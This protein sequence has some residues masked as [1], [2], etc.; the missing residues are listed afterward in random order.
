MNSYD[1]DNENSGNCSNKKTTKTYNNNKNNNQHESN[2]SNSNYRQQQ[3]SVGDKVLTERQLNVHCNEIF[4][5][6]EE[7]S[8]AREYNKHII[9]KKHGGIKET[10]AASC[11]ECDKR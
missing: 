7:A 8:D 10:L 9:K 11:V 2:S 6:S 1:G 3:L 4:T 5:V